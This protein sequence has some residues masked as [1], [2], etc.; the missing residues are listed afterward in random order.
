MRYLF[1]DANILLDF[2]RFGDDDIEEIGKIL[3]LINDKE[4][5][6]YSNSHL[7]AEVERN[8]EKVLAESLKSLESARFSVR[9]PN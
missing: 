3:A 4:I 6:L 8:R 2:Y 1:L 5:T 9:A 7:K